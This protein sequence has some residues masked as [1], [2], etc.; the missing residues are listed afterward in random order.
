MHI[1]NDSSLFVIIQYAFITMDGYII[2][3]KWILWRVNDEVWMLKSEW[4]RVDD[5]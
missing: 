5:G 2:L 4:W 3:Y 1:V